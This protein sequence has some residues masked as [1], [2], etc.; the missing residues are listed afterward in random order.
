MSE[1]GHEVTLI[2]Q[3][4]AAGDRD[5]NNELITLVYAQLR[6][7]AQGHFRGPNDRPQTLQPTAL[8]HE[9]VIKIFGKHPPTFSNREHFL[10][11]AASAMRS[12]LVDR[13]RARGTAKRGDNPTRVPIDEILVPFEN[14]RDISMV[15]LND[16]LERLALRSKQAARIV[17][18]R[19]FGGLEMNE[20]ANVLGIP[21]KAVERDWRTGRAWLRGQLDPDGERRADRDTRG[22]D[23]SASD[24]AGSDDRAA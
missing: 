14:N 13:A 8:V 24:D 11:V 7:L 4:I 23:R 2:L 10:G 20:I 1:P 6:T 17:E 3:R 16:A 5:A 12:I 9:A 18:L 19:Y 15:D 21:V 22:S